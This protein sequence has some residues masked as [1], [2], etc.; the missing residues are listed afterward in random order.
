[1][2]KPLHARRRHKRRLAAGFTLLEVMI[3]LVLLTIGL[4]GMA[5]LQTA[6]LKNNDS[7]L[8]R[9][10]AVALADSILDDIRA[11]RKNAASYETG[12]GDEVTDG[13][14]Q[15]NSDLQAWKASLTKFGGQ[16]QISYDPNGIYTVKV[17]WSENKSMDDSGKTGTQPKTVILRTK[18]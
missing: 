8:V 16:G 7:S 13:S 1:M 9:S 5:G 11:N 6:S 17:R 18:P 3:A 15:A 4:L 14:T 12:F 2:N 10:H